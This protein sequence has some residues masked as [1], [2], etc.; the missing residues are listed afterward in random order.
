VPR[1]QAQQDRRGARQQ[2]GGVVR[3]AVGLDHD[4]AAGAQVGGRIG[5]SD[6]AQV[7]ELELDA[8]GEGQRPDDHGQVEAHR[9]ELDEPLVARA[10]GAAAEHHGGSLAHDVTGG[11][12]L[13]AQAVVGRVRDGR[14]REV[15]TEVAVVPGGAERERLV[16]E[17]LLEQL[18]DVER[19]EL[20]RRHVAAGPGVAVAQQAAAAVA[21]RRPELAL[22]DPGAAQQV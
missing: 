21:R 6:R 19:A 20:E 8:G 12:E 15:R 1:R 10:A 5:R 16:A 14:V 9:S 22:V 7:G 17:A 18:V 3:G 13:L 11:R 2:L 4:E